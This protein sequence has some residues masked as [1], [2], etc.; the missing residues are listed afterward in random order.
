MHF[1]QMGSPIWISDSDVNMKKYTYIVL[2]LFCILLTGCGTIAR[3]S[4]GSDLPRIYGATRF[5][6]YFLYGCWSPFR[7]KSSIID[8]SEFY[9]LT[10][11]A[12]IDIPLAMIL[13]TALLPWGVYDHYKIETSTNCS[14]SAIKR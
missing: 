8:V 4:K 1:I 5:D 3:C 9:Y 7:Q 6:C 12:I 11:F 2:A 13:D 14:S 10:P